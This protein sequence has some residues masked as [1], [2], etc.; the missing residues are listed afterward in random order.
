M[1]H[2]YTNL[3]CDHLLTTNDTLVILLRIFI[4]AL[5]WMLLHVSSN[6]V[7]NSFTGICHLLPTISYFEPHIRALEYEYKSC[8]KNYL[9]RKCTGDHQLLKLL[10]QG[11]GLNLIECILHYPEGREMKK[12]PRPKIFGDKDLHACRRN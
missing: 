7:H 9:R 11:H 5:I 3:K 2:L 12:R 6:I 10:P 4:Y 8:R 1:W